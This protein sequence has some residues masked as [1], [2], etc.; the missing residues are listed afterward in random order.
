MNIS[1]FPF[2]LVL[3]GQFWILGDEGGTEGRK[4]AKYCIELLTGYSSKPLL[5]RLDVSNA[6]KSFKM[7]LSVGRD[8]FGWSQLSDGLP[9]G[10][11]PSVAGGSYWKQIWGMGGF[12]KCEC[13]LL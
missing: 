3:L 4:Q 6:C 1:D 8:A 7:R 2:L 12:L 13:H 5:F 9:S 11:L 10:G